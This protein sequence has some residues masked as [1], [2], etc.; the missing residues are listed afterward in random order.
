MDPHW[1]F[2]NARIT[3]YYLER[4]IAER[5]NPVKTVVENISGNSWRCFSWIEKDRF[6]CL[7]WNMV[8][9][10]ERGQKDWETK[11]QQREV[12]ITNLLL[13]GMVELLF[14]NKPR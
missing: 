8:F 9:N 11:A 12:L 4:K 2:R 13:G 3:N 10:R 14:Y 1:E 5:L 6:P 7:T